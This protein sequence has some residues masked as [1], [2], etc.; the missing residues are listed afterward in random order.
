MQVMGMNVN[1]RKIFVAAFWCL[2]GI[3]ILILLGAAIKYRNNK[4]CKGYKIEISGPSGELFIGKK[5]IND[6]LTS[7]GAGKWQDRAIPSFDLRRMESVLEKN[8]WIRDA[9]LFFDNNGI[10]RVNV[11]E[12]EPAT[13]IFTEGGNSFYIDSSGV[14]LPLSD[15]LPVKLPVFTDYPAQGIRLH[16]EDSLLTVQIRQLSGFIRNDPFWMAQIAQVA[17]TPDRNFELVPTVGNHLIEFGDGSDYEQKF[18]RLF[19]FYKEVLSRTGLDK[20]SRIDIAYAGQVIG[21][22]KGSEGTRFDS[23]QGMKNIQQMI[24][25]AQQLQA[26]TV[27]QMNPRPLEHSTETEQ[28]LT[29]HDLIPDSPSYERPPP[30]KPVDTHPVSNPVRTTPGAPP[31]RTGAG[32]EPLRTPGEPDR[33][34]PKPGRTGPKAVMPKKPIKNN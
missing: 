19:I 26:D 11:I 8:I 22:K 31:L 32:K 27:R 21:T 33:E 20:Y 14:Q 16:G 13:R 12:R 7:A 4:T 15:K 18:H 17:I 23:I 2:A 30:A 28:T 34:K 5:E 9:Q 3:G 10:L 29:N 6:L 25:S 1:I 24:R